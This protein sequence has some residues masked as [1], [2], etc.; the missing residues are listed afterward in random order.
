MM[1]CLECFLQ[2]KAMAL[3]NGSHLLALYGKAQ[4][5]LDSFPQFIRFSVRI[6]IAEARPIL[7]EKGVSS[8]SEDKDAWS[9]LMSLNASCSITPLNQV[10]DLNDEYMDENFAI[11]AF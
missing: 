6:P 8:T 7:S 1:A 5:G 3:S 2:M 11:F 9:T 10:R 4:P